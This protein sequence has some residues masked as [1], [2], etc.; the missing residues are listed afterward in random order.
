[1]HQEVFQK[2]SFI[3]ANDETRIEEMKI[4]MMLIECTLI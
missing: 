1:V 3:P 4:D 2:L